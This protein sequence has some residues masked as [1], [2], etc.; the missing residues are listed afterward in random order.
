ME[1][2]Q[3]G[4][5][6]VMS[7]SRANPMWEMIKSQYMINQKKIKRAESTIPSP[8]IKLDP[9]TSIDVNEKKNKE[10]NAKKIQNTIHFSQTPAT[11]N[12]KIVTNKIIINKKCSLGEKES[13]SNSVNTTHKSIH[14][15]V[16]E[17]TDT[18]RHVNQE[19]EITSTS[20]HSVKDF[21]L[22]LGLSENSKEDEIVNEEEDPR[23]LMTIGFNMQETIEVEE[24]EPNPFEEK[25]LYTWPEQPAPKVVK[26]MVVCPKKKNAPKKMRKKAKS[27][28]KRSPNT[29]IDVEVKSTIKISKAKTNKK[30]NINLLT[31]GFELMK[32]IPRTVKSLNNISQNKKDCVSADLVQE[33]TEPSVESKGSMI[34][35]SDMISC[36][37]IVQTKKHKKILGKK[38]S[39]KINKK[40][41]KTRKIKKRKEK[42]FT[43]K[44]QNM[45]II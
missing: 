21:K 39:R 31:Q 45:Y 32:K 1:Y 19:I 24:R 25:P 7:S 41:R 42:R 11:Q 3:D 15:D 18:S 13:N 34:G 5:W 30:V 6:I 17:T 38:K 8:N 44:M 28:K 20:E 27:R 23:D 43:V 12:I 9:I 22:D 36:N 29:I 26:P 33:K 40:S 37:T 10:V 4:T 35:L 14:I 2:K 16:D